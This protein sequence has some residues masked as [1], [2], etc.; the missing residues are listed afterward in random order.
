MVY[1]SDLLEWLRERTEIDFEIARGQLRAKHAALP[2]PNEL[3]EYIKSPDFKQ[4]TLF[5]SKFIE[6]PSY[7]HSKILMSLTKIVFEQLDES[8]FSF[9]VECIKVKILSNGNNRKPD[10]VLL[11]QDAKVSHNYSETSEPHTIFE[12]ISPSTE[13]IDRGEKKEEYL[14]LNSLQEYVL[15]WQDQPKIEQYLRTG[16]T[17]WKLNI[18]DNLDQ[19]L[20][21]SVGVEI[22]LSKL[23]KDISTH[24]K[25]E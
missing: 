11:L 1:D 10:G 4:S 21:L 13:A 25:F 18:Y 8:N 19:T 15:I 17:E 7:N 14:S 12:I 2:L 6:M 3:L 24:K 22:K 20:V 9:Y 23:Y 16:K 5:E